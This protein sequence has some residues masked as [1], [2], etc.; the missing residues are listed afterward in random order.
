[1]QVL[2]MI[3]NKKIRDLLLFLLLL[4]ASKFAI[5]RTVQQAVDLHHNNTSRLHKPFKVHKPDKDILHTIK[6]TKKRIHHALKGCD[7]QDLQL[8]LC[9]ME[10][11]LETIEKKV[12]NTS[13]IT[14]LL[15]PIGT[16]A[17]VL[18][19]KKAHNKLLKMNK[20]LDQIAT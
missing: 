20:Q 16:T 4:V 15:G 13:P 3:K 12:T 8:Q 9:K 11:D 1:M 5:Q 6:R 14:F 2:K 19:E 18:K 17:V 7:T 10:Q